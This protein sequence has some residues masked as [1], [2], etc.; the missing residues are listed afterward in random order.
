MSRELST[1]LLLLLHH[2]VR[3]RGT[4]FVGRAR[5]S[6]PGVAAPRRIIVRFAM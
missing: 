1:Q 3:R 2:T 4:G 6:P 5:G